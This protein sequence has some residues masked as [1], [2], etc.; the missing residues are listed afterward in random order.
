[1][2]LRK[3]SITDTS[4]R[5]T[6][7]R[8][9]VGQEVLA[10][11]YRLERLLGEGFLGP[12]WLALDRELSLKRA[13]RFVSSRMELS[14][15][16][17]NDVRTELQQCQ[18]LT[19][20]N[21]AHLHDC[22]QDGEVLILAT[23]YVNGQDLSL[24][25]KRRRPPFF[26]VE[27]VRFWVEE[28]CRALHF[29]HTFSKKAHGDLNPGNLF[30]NKQGHLKVADFQIARVLQKHDIYQNNHELG[31]VGIPDY[32]SPQQLHGHPLEISDD[33]YSFGATLFTLFGG[34][35]PFIGEDLDEQI[36]HQPAPSLSAIR[37]A[38]GSP[39]TPFPTEWEDTIAACLLKQPSER[40]TS[41][42]EIA[43]RL[44]LELNSVVMR[45]PVVP[46]EFTEIAS[47]STGA[48][49]TSSGRRGV[50]ISAID[51]LPG[52]QEPTTE[53]RVRALQDLPDRSKHTTNMGIIVWIVASLTGGSILF[54][55]C[56][57]SGRKEI[58]SN[59]IL[60][61][62]PV[63]KALE[64]TPEV[65]AS[66]KLPLTKP[67]TSAQTSS[68]SWRELQQLVDDGN[69]R[70]ASERIT[71]F[72][73]GEPINT[74]AYLASA[75]IHRGLNQTNNALASL[76]TLLEAEPNHALAARMKSLLH[77]EAKQWDRALHAVDWAMVQK[78]NERNAELLGLRGQ[79]NRHLGNLDQA[80]ADF[81]KS[82]RLQP[83]AAIYYWRGI[84]YRDEGNLKQALI[85]L[86]EAVNMDP[87]DTATR[88]ARAFLTI[89][90]D[91][92]SDS[93]I[94]DLSQVLRQTPEGDREALFNRMVCHYEKDHWKEVIADGNRSSNRK[95]PL[96][97]SPFLPR[98]CSYR[99]GRFRFSHRRLTGLP[100]NQSE[101]P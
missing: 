77:G 76:R 47:S 38:S 31:T 60:S 8:L 53:R 74:Q 20:P 93:V 85:D 33:V 39:P 7:S 36:Q 13:L 34:R 52:R 97:R 9:V 86:N 70:L 18:N 12:L 51:Q 50:G 69:W 61:E 98:L 4:A 78:G 95:P 88:R 65:S 100:K 19:H 54:S 79:A 66:Q 14:Q 3:S 81:T 96:E 32:Q 89:Q 72:L 63:A 27:E 84:T 59:A 37:I 6:A 92:I 58:G 94:A 10:R 82:L 75:R 1:M 68:A 49:S 67:H 28:C 15:E 80:I 16:A 64:T 22:H 35:P 101:R 29:A 56:H 90:L 44:K 21:I 40:P 23:D 71:P 26:D 17:W 99:A 62:T 2:N 57:R 48:R 73:N 46:A 45:E 43:E 11:R 91:Q 87:I 24:A 30:I 41:V 25:G 5:A 55:Q 42:R 83:T